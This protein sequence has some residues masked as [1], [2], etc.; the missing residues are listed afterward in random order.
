MEIDILKNI[1]SKLDEGYNYIFRIHLKY[2]HEKEIR[3]IN[4]ILLSE[5]GEWVW[6]NDWYEG[7]E[8]VHIVG[9]I[10]VDDVYIC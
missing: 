6:L 3:D 10:K 1:I 7:E 5:D 8:Y 2:N 9:Y 4:V